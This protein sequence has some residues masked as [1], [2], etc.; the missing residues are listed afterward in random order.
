MRGHERIKFALKKQSSNIFEILVTVQICNGDVRA[1]FKNTVALMSTC[2]CKPR[3]I[4]RGREETPPR[5]ASARPPGAGEAVKSK[6]QGAGKR[7]SAGP[8]RRNIPPCG[9]R[10]WSEQGRAGADGS[11]PPR[12]R[13]C[14]QRQQ[15]SAGAAAGRGGDRAAARCGG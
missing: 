2:F 11:I 9:R 1:Y 5:S 4:Q 7:R 13:S 15:P 6:A 12:S 14:L 3:C 8:E 10:P